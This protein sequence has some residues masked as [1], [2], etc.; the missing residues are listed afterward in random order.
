MTLAARVIPCLEST[1]CFRNVEQALG[2]ILA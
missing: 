2:Q 1:P